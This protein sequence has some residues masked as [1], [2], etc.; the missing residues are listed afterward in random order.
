MDDA[1]DLT[2]PLATPAAR[3][4]RRSIYWLLDACSEFLIYGT[5]IFSLWAFGSTERWSI[6][7]VNQLCYLLGG[8]L[9]GKWVARSAWRLKPARWDDPG[10]LRGENPRFITWPLAGLTFLLL[11][12]IG[13]SAWNARAEFLWN[14]QRFEYYTK[15]IPWLPHSYDGSLTWGAFRVY[16][17]AAIYFWALRDWLGTKGRREMRLDEDGDGRAAIGPDVAELAGAYT[18]DPTRF[19]TRLKRLLWVLCGNAAALAVQG[20]IQRLSNS[21]ELLWMVSPRFNHLASEQFGPFSYGSNGAQYLNMI[22]PMA[23][24]FWWALNQ[25]R[26]HKFGEGSEFLLLPMTG[27]MIVGAISSN[28]RGGLAICAAEIIGVL[29]IFAYSFR[30]G[31]WWKTALVA[32]L[33]G[34]IVA[35]SVALN[36]APLQER[37]KENSYNDFSRRLEI[38]ENS[39]RIAEEFSL[40]GT[41]PGTFAYVYPL[42]RSNPAQARYAMAHDDYLQTRVTFGR[43]GFTALMFVLVMIF[44]YWFLARGIPTSELFV[45]FV[46]LGAA[47]CLMHARFDFP[48]QVYSVFLVFVTLSAILTTLAR[49][50]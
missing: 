40:W 13:V 33:L 19:P 27:L 9:V 29:G 37:F 32:S 20:V 21:N 39:S 11:L 34:I 45:G 25:Q 6:E 47:G 41:G 22:W 1:T 42:Y 23:L 28:S 49:R 44:A 48:L 2:A 24:A 30:K 46:W 10:G 35:A 7:T 14:E 26:N 38:Y 16:L 17:A 8:L 12:F 4:Q 18:Y 15:F 5:L 50:S 3:D 36:W 31:G 43:V